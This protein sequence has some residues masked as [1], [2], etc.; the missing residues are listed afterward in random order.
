MCEMLVFVVDRVNDDPIL[1]AKCYKRG[2]VV[3]VCEDGWDWSKEEKLNPD[4]KIVKAKG[5]SVDDAASF[6][7]PEPET[8]PLNPSPVLQRRA[9]KLKLDDAKVSKIQTVDD[10]MSLKVGKQRKANPFIP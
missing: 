4:W 10:L 8:D 1:D 9:F 5:L 6:M 3:V 7:A 2:D